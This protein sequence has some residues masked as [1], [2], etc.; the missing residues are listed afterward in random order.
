MQ[1]HFKDK[2]KKT[3]TDFGFELLYINTN[4]TLIKPE[5]CY[6][7]MKTIAVCVCIC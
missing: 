5:W 4:P 2:K 6:M 1:K 3:P 7:K